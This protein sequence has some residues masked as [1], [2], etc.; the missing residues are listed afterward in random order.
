MDVDLIMP[1]G[2]SPLEISVPDLH[3]ERVRVVAVAS[4]IVLAFAVWLGSEAP[5]GI[6]FGSD[7]LLTAERSRRD[8]ND[9]AMGSSLQL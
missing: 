6:V 9:R 1:V 7:E 5:R 4:L 2:V 3:R 8:A